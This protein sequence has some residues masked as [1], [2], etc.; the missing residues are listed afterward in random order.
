[1]NPNATFFSSFAIGVDA[2]ILLGGAYKLTRNLWMAM[3]FHAAWNFT[4]GFIWDAPVYGLDVHGLVTVSLT[5]PNW[6]SGGEFGLEAAVIALVCPTALGVF[7]VRKSYDMGHFV[8]P[9][10]VRRRL[11]WATKPASL[12]A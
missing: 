7:F 4:E 9:R 11:A 1:M 5:E 12:P 3:G 6:L 10:W 2:G 8:Q